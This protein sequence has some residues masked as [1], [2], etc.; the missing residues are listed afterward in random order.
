M[1][2]EGEFRRIY[3][4]HRDAVHAYFTART[5]DRWQAADLMQETFLR[6]WR[7]FPQLTGLSADGQ[8]AWLF[9]VARNL[10]IDEHRQTR[11]RAAAV[12][13]E[14]PDVAEPAST[15][16]IAAERVAVVAEAIKRLPEQQRVTLTLAAAGGLTSAEIATALGVP[17]GTVRY[18]LSL[19]RRTLAAALTIYDDLEQP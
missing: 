17:A 14:P 9:T 12:R 4:A 1:D 6:A 8:R 18:R 2:R 15:S 13:P 16:V 3:D 11:T 7:R 10:S 19:A 5:G